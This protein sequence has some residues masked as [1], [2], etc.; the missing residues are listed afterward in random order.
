MQQTAE[1][2]PGSSHEII[3]DEKPVECD[4][5]TG[6]GC[7]IGNIMDMGYGMLTSED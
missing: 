3:A 2:A 7:S 4:P 1:I 6:E 5:A